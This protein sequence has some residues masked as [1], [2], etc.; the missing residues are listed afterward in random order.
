MNQL[1][2]YN[3]KVVCPRCDG[4]GLIY[5][6]HISSLGVTVYLCDECEAMW[7]DAKTISI[8]SFKDFT[9]YLRGH[10]V[11]YGDAKLK[12]VNYAWHNGKH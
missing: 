5:Q 8:A 10:G 3:D 6:A 9:T 12:D 1:V 7:E 2:I 4:N 11:T